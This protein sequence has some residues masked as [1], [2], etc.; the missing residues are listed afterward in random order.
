MDRYSL[1]SFS[2]K[3]LTDTKSKFFNVTADIVEANE[4]KRCHLKLRPP[5][6][7]AALFYR[8]MRV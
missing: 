4:R 8:I 7:S 5:K 1:N 2:F 6:I 3:I